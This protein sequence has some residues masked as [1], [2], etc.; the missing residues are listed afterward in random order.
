MTENF[1]H[2]VSD[3]LHLARCFSMKA[4]W[5]LPKFSTEKART[6]LKYPLTLPC[7]TLGHTEK[8]ARRKLGIHRQFGFVFLCLCWNIHFVAAP[9]W[10]DALLGNWRK[11]TWNSFAKLMRCVKNYTPKSA[12]FE[13]FFVDCQNCSQDSCYWTNW[14]RRP[15]YFWLFKTFGMQYM[16]YFL[17]L[18]LSLVINS[19]SKPSTQYVFYMMYIVLWI[20]Y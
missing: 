10:C 7:R 19:S 13:Y 3:L 5:F 8:C 14:E 6:V 16:I 2:F 1:L 9:Y 15:L 17:L 20:S 12:Y 11:K 18:I 4:S